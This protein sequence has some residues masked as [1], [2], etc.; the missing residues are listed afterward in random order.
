MYNSNRVFDIKNPF[1]YSL[2]LQQ[3]VLEAM[4]YQGYVT[5]VTAAINFQVVLIPKVSAHDVQYV[6]DVQDE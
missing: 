6:T 4:H 1:S 5:S 3:I 2:L